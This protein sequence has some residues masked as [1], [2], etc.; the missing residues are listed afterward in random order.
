MKTSRIIILA[1]LAAVAT[2][3]YLSVSSGPDPEQ[4]AA[5]INEERKKKD[6]FLKEDDT[7]PLLPEDRDGF[8]ELKYFAPDLRY[9]ILANLEPVTNKQVR[10]LTTS[11]SE[12]TRYLEYAWATFELDGKENRL[13]ILEVMEMGPNRGK[14][15]LAFADD[16][17]AGETYGGG[18]YLD[19]KKIPAAT[20]IEL[21]FNKAY[22]PYCAYN[23]GYSCPLP[24]T[25]NILKV[26]ILA[27]EKTFK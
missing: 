2:V 12:Q 8:K 6:V 24:P 21:D 14:L 4:Y 23:D 17:S 20:S 15:F 19:L 16:T 18:R 22:N 11:T 1:S 9:N 13:L 26:A 10:V 27:G 7:S 3:F 25:E 5:E